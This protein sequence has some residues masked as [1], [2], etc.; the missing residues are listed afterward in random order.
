MLYEGGEDHPT[1]KAR[2][3]ALNAFLKLGKTS[4]GTTFSPWE[5]GDLK[6]LCLKGGLSAN[7]ATHDMCLWCIVDRRQL[8]SLIPSLRRSVNLIRMNSH[9]PPLESDTGEPIFPFTCPGCESVFDS[10]AHQS[11]ENLTESERKQFPSIH[12]GS[13]WHQ[14]PCTSTEMDHMVPCV[15]HMRLRFMCTLWDWC[16]APSVLVKQE[17]VAAT[18]LKM[19]QQD[20]VNTNRLKKL[21]DFKDVQAVKN[22]SFDGQ[23][24][25]KVMGRF[26]DYLKACKSKFYALG[27]VV[28][29]FIPPF[30]HD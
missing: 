20:G 17:A 28:Y 14:A 23:G 9:L 30:S 18:I 8:G 4:A 26:E 2:F 5:G 25:D 19:L 6:Y 29:L 16:I 21:N 24:C 7:F 1:L 11:Q 3:E 22:A 12:S 10:P 13:V 27:F 15:L